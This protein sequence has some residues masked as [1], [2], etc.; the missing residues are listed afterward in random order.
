MT[1]VFDPYLP[2]Q[3]RSVRFAR[4]DQNVKNVEEGIGRPI[5]AES[6]RNFQILGFWK[7]T[8]LSE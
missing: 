1:H 3:R 2:T 7:V 8:K 5:T 4:Q 6:D